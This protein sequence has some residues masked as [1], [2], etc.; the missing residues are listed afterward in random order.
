M[1]KVVGGGFLSLIGSIWFIAIYIFVYNNQ[2]SS[3]D[4]SVGRFVSS[5]AH[6]GMIFPLFISALFIICGIL[7]LL[8]E[9]FR[10][11]K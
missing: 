6:L 5:A 4:T 11:E 7:M 10:K 8:F 1:K 9:C 3:W 2:V